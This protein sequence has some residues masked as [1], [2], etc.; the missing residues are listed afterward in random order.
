MPELSLLEI[1]RLVDGQLVNGRGD[2]KIKDFHFD[3][4][5]IEDGNTLFFALKSESGDVH[6]YIK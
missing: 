5:L 4:R 1:S 2:F 6:Q 3:S